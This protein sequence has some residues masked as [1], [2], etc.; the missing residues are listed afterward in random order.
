MI[1]HIQSQL[2]IAANRLRGK[3]LFLAADDSLSMRIP[4]TEKFVQLCQS[5]PEMRVVD[6]SALTPHALIYRSRADAGAVLIG[7]T[8][9]SAAIVSLGRSPSVMYDEQARHIGT[10]PPLV[11]AGDLRALERALQGRGNAIFF[12]ACCIR[13]G[14]TRDRLVFNTE[15]FEKCSQA[16]VLASVT[17]HRIHRIPLWVRAI[18]GR[19]LKKDQRRAA[20]AFTAGEIPQGMNAY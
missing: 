10:S 1:E 4:G 8:R 14:M 18:A 7:Q 19:R 9:W 3:G 15:L 12:G 5:D 2:T 20:A 11:P 16:F 6:F 13:I 17:G